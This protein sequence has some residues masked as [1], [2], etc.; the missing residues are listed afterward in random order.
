MSKI[1]VKLISQFNSDSPPTPLPGGTVFVYQDTRELTGDVSELTLAGYTDLNGEILLD[2][3]TNFYYIATALYLTEQNLIV[4]SPNTTNATPPNDFNS[5]Q[6]VFET[7][8]S[9]PGTT[10]VI[11][12]QNLINAQNAAANPGASVTTKIGPYEIIPFLTTNGYNQN[13]NAVV[14]FNLDNTTSDKTINLVITPE[15]R[16]SKFWPTQQQIASIKPTEEFLSDAVIDVSR[17]TMVEEPD[18]KAS[19]TAQVNTEVSTQ[20]NKTLDNTLKSQLSPQARIAKLFNK[21]KI[22]IK[23]KLIPAI[24]ALLLPFGAAVVQGILSKLPLDTLKDLTS[25]P[26]RS[27]LE[28]L[29]QK[30]NNLVR[31]INQIYKIVTTLAKIST[32]LSIAIAAIRVGIL[33]VTVVPLPAP[34]AVPVGATKLRDEL[35]KVS[36]VVNVVTVILATIGT[37]LGVI[38]VLLKSLDA[39]IEHCVEVS[40]TPSLQN[41][42]ISPD[43]AITRAEPIS[44]E[45]INTEL[46]DFVNESTGISNSEVIASTQQGNIYKGFKLELQYDTTF[47]PNYPRRYA[48]ALNSQGIPVLKTESS[49][50]SDAQVLLDQLKFIIDSNPQLTAE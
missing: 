35:K 6:N 15:A 17:T 27:K 33:A 29:I 31:Q 42:E 2:S 40:N 26:S 50:A 28:Q 14:V 21:Q 22:Q 30:R 19:T 48:Q 5:F 45:E 49:F 11:T 1:K 18:I 32:T 3:A 7:T 47:N 9:T 36:V 39:L 44:F 37:L 24:I 41:E 38:L 43:G 25:C 20:N 13:I 4:T 46:N 8:P 10:T 34:P 23:K 16:A 12:D